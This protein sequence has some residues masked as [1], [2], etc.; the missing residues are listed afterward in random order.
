MKI[1]V[2][3]TLNI[4]VSYATLFG[5][6]ETVNKSDTV[7]K[8]F[9]YESGNYKAYSIL[10]PDGDKIHATL[11]VA[12][13]YAGQCNCIRSI[14]TDSGGLQESVLSSS[15]F[16]K[17]KNMHDAQQKELSKADID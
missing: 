14:M 11:F 12:G 3:L 2:F 4:I 15:V 9:Y 1:K 5:M 10:L 7:N 13:P 8:V 17:L 6:K 16:D